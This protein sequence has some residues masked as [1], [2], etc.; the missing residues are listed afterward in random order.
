[1]ANRGRQFAE[2]PAP[3]LQAALTRASATLRMIQAVARP[4]YPESPE[5]RELRGLEKGELDALRQK[6]R[7]LL[8]DLRAELRRRGHF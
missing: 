5:L 4:T 7:D 2:E 1:M 6:T 3:Q 8:T